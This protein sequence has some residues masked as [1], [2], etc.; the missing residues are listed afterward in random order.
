MLILAMLFPF[1]PRAF[2]YYINA[3]THTELH[4]YYIPKQNAVKHI[5]EAAMDLEE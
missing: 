2:L 3:H 5:A 4:I 1:S